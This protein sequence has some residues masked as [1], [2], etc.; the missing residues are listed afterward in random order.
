MRTH[1]LLLLLFTFLA[2][3]M[4]AGVAQAQ[5]PET[6]TSGSATGGRARSQGASQSS[7]RIEFDELAIHSLDPRY[8]KLN[9]DRL[10]E[11]RV[12]A[13]RLFE[14]RKDFRRE[15]ADILENWGVSQ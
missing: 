13:G 1:P 15:Q 14:P 5:T 11:D 2:L 4:N 12:G 8:S 9:V 7:K 10:N 6:S 3:L